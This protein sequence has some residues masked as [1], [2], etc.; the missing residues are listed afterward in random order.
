[1]HRVATNTSTDSTITA[2][3]TGTGTTT[4]TTTIGTTISTT[5]GTTIST[6]IGTGT[7]TGTGVGIGI[8][9]GVGI[10]MAPAQPTKA[11]GCEWCEAADHTSGPTHE[12][13]WVRSCLR[14]VASLGYRK[15]C[16]FRRRKEVAD[17]F[18]APA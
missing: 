18:S 11:G 10:G 9:T 16:S 5:I 1:M 14:G 12:G 13:G 2:T 8:G 6:T 7:G 15:R 17:D 3:G 4:T